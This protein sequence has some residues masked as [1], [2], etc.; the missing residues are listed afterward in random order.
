M[1]CWRCGHWVERPVWRRITGPT[2]A[3]P[4]TGFGSLRAWY[5]DGAGDTW[6]VECR[7]SCAE[8]ALA[9]R[10]EALGQDAALPDRLAW[11]VAELAAL[12][13]SI[14]ARHERELALLGW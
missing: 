11:E 12:A 8:T 5:S 2:T 7:P 13:K 3:R 4:T 1:V 14:A 10:L 9:R 6:V